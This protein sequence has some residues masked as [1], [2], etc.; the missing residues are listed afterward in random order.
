MQSQRTQAIAEL[1][2]QRQY[3]A[4]E[5][6]CRTQILLF[7]L[8]QDLLCLLGI[9]LQLLNKPAEA[10]H[11]YR[12][13]LDINANEGLYWNNFGTALRETGA[14][15]EARAA[16]GKALELSP[17]DSE[18]LFNQ[19]LLQF[20][21]AEYP[22]ARETLLQ[23]HR[24]DS[25]SAQIRVHAAKACARCKDFL[26]VEQLLRSWRQ[27]LPTEETEL[28][29]ELADM[30]VLL[31]DVVAA[32]AILKNLIARLPMDLRAKIRLL[33]VYERS[34]RLDLANAYMQELPAPIQI[35]NEELR[36][37]LLDAATALAL[38][39]KD[40]ATAKRHLQE[41]AALAKWESHHYFSLAHIHHHENDADKAMEALHEAHALQMSELR[42]EVPDRFAED[43]AMLP[44]AADIVDD[45]QFTQ[46]PN[47]TAPDASNSPIFIVGFPRSGT[48]LLEQMLDAHPDFKS[49]DERPF[50]NV[51]ADHL[52][53][54]GLIMPRDLFKLDAK[55]CDQLRTMYWQMVAEKIE[56]HPGIRLVDKN[57]LNMLWLPLIYRI[58]P[59]ARIILALRHPCDVILSCY[60]QSFRS[61]ILGAASA[62]LNDLATTYV[63][64][65]R[66]WLHH[67]ELFNPNVMEL[68]HE[69][70]TANLYNSAER[71]GKFI[72]IH[73]IS[74][75]LAF[76]TH[77]RNKK[78]IGTPSYTQVIEPI[79]KKGIDRWLRYQSHLQSAI[80]IL[81]PM[82]DH[83]GYLA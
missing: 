60:M 26:A 50:F 81:R 58:F 12:T 10:V 72:G 63:A 57:P 25:G 6:L 61:A 79:N 34:N 21:L 22:A 82:L 28:H 30:L 66:H 13:L 18:V 19:G 20:Q 41:S 53:N 24:L 45:H 70:L 49:M 9:T 83:W 47:L 7:P 75:L 33:T 76:D 1:L 74:P 4:A 62:S 68:R 64:A 51:L 8:D 3:L 31:G 43:V 32:E 14:L 37:A 52:D 78:F 35:A 2:G 55:D 80:P 17:R 40:F 39:M 36:R 59:H 71:I 46:W 65:M 11:T 5:E 54:R 42:L 16:Y 77:A 48:T 73:D 38:R 44:A 56:L 67:V 15:S 23:A 29:H 27:W 69:D